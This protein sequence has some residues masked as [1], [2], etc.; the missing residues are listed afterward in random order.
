[1]QIDIQTTILMIFIVYLVLHGAIW[2]ASTG[3]V[4]GARNNT[5][6]ITL[7]CVS[8][9]VSGLA[10]I[11]LALRGTVPD[12]VFFYL[13][14]FLMLVGNFGRIIA[15]KM[16]VSKISKRFYWIEGSLYVIYF[17]V[18]SGMH[19]LEYNDRS[20]M[21]LFFGF[22]VFACL[23]YFLVGLQLTKKSENLAPKILMAAGLS[24]SGTLAF[25]CIAIIF[26]F[27]ASGLYELGVDQYVMIAGQFVAI[28]LSNIAFLKID[29]NAEHDSRFKTISELAQSKM[30][31]SMLSEHSEL[32]NKLVLEREEILRQLMMSN[33]SATMG[34]L[35]ASFAHE[36]NQPL[37]SIRLNAQLI[38]K[39]IDEDRFEPIQAKEIIHD[40][41]KDNKRASDII[42]KLRAMFDNKNL[43]FVP[44]NI[45]DLLKDTHDLVKQK[46][47]NES[48]YLEFDY[49]KIDSI[50]GDIT[51]LQ[52]VFLNLINNA[53]EALMTV[54]RAKKNIIVSTSSKNGQITVKVKDN[55]PGVSDENKDSVFELFKTTKK[56]GM[57]I[58]LWLSQASVAAHHGK[59][60]FTSELGVGSEFEVQLGRIGI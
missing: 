48:I 44:V 33:K 18:F 43:E 51:Q 16:F 9:I 36:L 29:I 22:Y 11:L 38:E 40:L 15:L 19:Y 42:L 59:I 32:L 56:A 2:V 5:F 49:G 20:L 21:I 17:C 53:I 7:W 41:I 13:A 46:L 60:S 30:R 25:K 35:A 54:E 37:G 27:G 4:R 34:A 6:Q 12:P 55:G 39:R 10:V 31:S 8:G 57:G 58:G 45:N 47:I 24:F 26:G 28:T 1:M 52:Q 50:L 23:D 3:S 14:Q